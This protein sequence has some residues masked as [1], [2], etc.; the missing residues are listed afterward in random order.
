VSTFDKPQYAEDFGFLNHTSLP[1]NIDGL[2]ERHGKFLFIEV[3]RGE[4]IS[5][6]QL[7]MLEALSRVPN[8][9]VLVLNSRW[10]EADKE[11]NSR[12]VVPYFYR[13]VVDG[14]LED[15]VLSDDRD[16]K[17]RYHQWFATQKRDVWL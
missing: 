10:V 6:G 16:F 14:V 1:S 13:L 12:R 4:E 3:K 9:T 5:P 8:F 7:I 2:T 11:T 15:P 17:I